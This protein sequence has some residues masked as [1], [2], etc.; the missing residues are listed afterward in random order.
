MKLGY[1]LAPWIRDGHLDH[2]HRA[3]DEISLS[4]WDGLE[5][6]GEWAVATWGQ[7]PG[8]LRSLLAL[9]DLE[10]ASCYAGFSYLHERRGQ[11]TETA[12]RVIGLAAEAGCMILLIDGGPQRP[13]GTGEDDYRRVAEFANQIGAWTREAGLQCCWH[14]HWGTIFEW[15]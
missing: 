11:E 10:L 7:R 3:L 4:G 12:R 13:E 1:H 6:L 2:F 9:H 8:E 15:R 5:L 14:Q